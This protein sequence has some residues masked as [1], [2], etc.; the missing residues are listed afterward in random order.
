MTMTKA[1]KRAKTMKAHATKRSTKRSTKQPAPAA[2]LQMT[3]PEPALVLE[4]DEGPR[5]ELCGEPAGEGGALCPACAERRS[6]PV[7][8]ADG[9]QDAPAVVG[10]ATVPPVM[11]RGQGASPAAQLGRTV[12]RWLKDQQRRGGALTP[13]SEQDIVDKTR[14]ACRE[15]VIELQGGQE[16]SA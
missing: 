1:T 10:E 4:V 12:V 16:V 8:P 9:A 14:E 11:T 5:C 3:A 2:A 13:R 7:A 15:A 6:V